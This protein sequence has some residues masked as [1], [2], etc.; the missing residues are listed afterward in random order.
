MSALMPS[1]LVTGGAGFIGSNLVHLL[2]SRTDHTVVVVDKVTYAAN[3]KTVEE[4]RGTAGIG[5]VQ[6]DIADRAAME[7]LLTAHRAWAILNL[8]AETHV[9]RSIDSPGA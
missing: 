6:A 2:L 1:V 3:P 8:A 4:L 5:F 7:Q 9:D